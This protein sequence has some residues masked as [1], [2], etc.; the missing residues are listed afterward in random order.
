MRRYYGC[1]NLTKP[2]L[3]I[4]D[5]ISGDVTAYEQIFQVCANTTWETKGG[6]HDKN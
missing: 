1:K 3:K 2:N 6:C 4:V 5:D